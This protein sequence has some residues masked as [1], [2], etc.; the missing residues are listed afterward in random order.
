MCPLIAG[1]HRLLQSFERCMIAGRKTQRIVGR[2]PTRAQHLQRKLTGAS[3][4]L[5]SATALSK[6]AAGHPPSRR[7]SSRA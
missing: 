5:I 4:V 7:R 1:V 6:P 2:Q 3:Q